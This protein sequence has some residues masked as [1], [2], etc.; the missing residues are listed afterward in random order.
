MRYSFDAGLLDLGR[1]R[2]VPFKE[3]LEEMVALVA[4]DAAVLGCSAE[5]ARLPDILTR[6]SS[7]HR[8]LQVYDRSSAAGATQD[9]ALREVVNWLVAETAR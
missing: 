2:V 8:Q 3:L 5:I 6:G 7:A 1:Q 9:E 4:E